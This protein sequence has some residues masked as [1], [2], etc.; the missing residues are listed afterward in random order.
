[1]IEWV[2]GSIGLVTIMVLL[3]EKLWR[4]AYKR[5]YDE[6]WADGRAFDAK[7]KEMVQVPYPEDANAA[8]EIL[9]AVSNGIRKSVG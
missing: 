2:I 6:G 5:G 8:K 4:T 7:P 9:E 3:S 1:M